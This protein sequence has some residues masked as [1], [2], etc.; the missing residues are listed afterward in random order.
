MK[1]LSKPFTFRDVRNIDPSYTIKIHRKFI[2]GEVIKKTTKMP[3]VN[4]VWKFNID[5]G[6]IKQL[7]G[8]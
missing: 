6:V 5:K 1:N 3:E 7:K 8:F 2:I 4:S